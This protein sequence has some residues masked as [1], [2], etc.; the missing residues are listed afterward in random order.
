MIIEITG[1][2]NTS[3]SQVPSR[4]A[5][6][7]NAVVVS[8]EDWRMKRGRP[9]VNIPQSVPVLDWPQDLFEDESISH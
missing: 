8:L 1:V 3:W 5:I 2:A 6:A 7:M 4:Q 9:Y